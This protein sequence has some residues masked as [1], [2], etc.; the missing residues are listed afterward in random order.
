MIRL[1]SGNISV[2]VVGW[3]SLLAKME[4]IAGGLLAEDAQPAASGDRGSGRTSE[5]MLDAPPRAVFVCCKGTSGYTQCLANHLGRNDLR[6]VGPSWLEDEGWRGGDFSAVVLDHALRLTAG[7]RR[8]LSGLLSMVRQRGETVKISQTPERQQLTPG[9]A[10]VD[11]VTHAAALWDRT[12]AAMGHRYEGEGKAQAQAAADRCGRQAMEH[13]TKISAIISAASE[14]MEQCVNDGRVTEARA[15]I[16][17]LDEMRRISD[18]MGMAVRL[19]CGNSSEP[20]HL[21]N[22]D[23]MW[24][25]EERAR[26]VTALRDGEPCG[27]PGCLAHVS[28]PCEGCGRVAGRRLVGG[29]G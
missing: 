15:W 19:A 16:D 21:V 1:D 29:D 26:R 24:K 18:S 6:I 17:A 12:L 13:R 3:D 20:Y 25:A 9:K 10:L 11:V 8:G 23:W 22:L 27:H 7:Q 4:E 28:H 14:A 5:Q 2:S